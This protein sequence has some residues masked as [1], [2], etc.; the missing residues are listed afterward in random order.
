MP[1]RIKDFAVKSF[2]FFIALRVVSG[3]ENVLHSENEAHVLESFR[4][5]LSSVAGEERNRRALHEQQV[6]NEGLANLDRG[7]SRKR[8]RPHQLRVP[9]CDDKQKPIPATSVD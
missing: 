5:E 4:G 9:V 1:Q 7:D 6:V 2:H 3:G 8:N